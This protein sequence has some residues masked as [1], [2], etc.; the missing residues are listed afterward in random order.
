MSSFY[1]IF[2]FNNA[3]ILILFDKNNTIWLSYNDIL[4]SLGYT[5]LKKLKRRLVIDRK[6]F[7]SYENIYPQSKLNKIKLDYQKP[8]EKFIN[9]SGIYLL[10]AQS[11]KPLA[12]E[13]SSKLF[14]IFYRN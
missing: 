12:K 9:E 11:N 13:L 14:M 8:N 1:N 10:L 7:D 4:N 2:K 6:F 5:D 3:N